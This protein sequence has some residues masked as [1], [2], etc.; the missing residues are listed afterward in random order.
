MRP[1]EECAHAIRPRGP[2]ARWYRPW[3]GCMVVQMCVVGA[4][5]DEPRTNP[6]RCILLLRWDDQCTKCRARMQSVQHRHGPGAAKAPCSVQ[7]HDIHHK[8][9]LFAQLGTQA[10]PTNVLLCHTWPHSQLGY[11]QNMLLLPAALA[12]HKNI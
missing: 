1:G 11:M 4:G 8:R 2:A 7:H 9:W 12:Q 10:H 6:A 3:Y 5:V